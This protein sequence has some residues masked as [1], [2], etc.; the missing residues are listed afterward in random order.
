MA[1]FYL[2]AAVRTV[3]EANYPLIVTLVILSLIS[4]RLEWTNL[5]PL[6]LAMAGAWQIVMGWRLRRSGDVVAG[7][8][9]S[10]VSAAVAGQHTWLYGSHGILPVHALLVILLAAGYWY[11][12][13]T[14][15]WARRA[16]VVLAVI[17]ASI[18]ALGDPSFLSE[19]PVWARMIYPLAMAALLAGYSHATGDV[20]TY[21]GGAAAAAVGCADYSG[22]A[23]GYLHHRVAGLNELAWALFF[24]LLAA[25]I[26]LLKSGLRPAW[27]RRKLP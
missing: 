20:W 13:Q 26:S 6:P 10:L 16:A 19:V 9:L 24:F 12:D 14:G 5:D 21:A 1:A 8:C 17:L 25:L 15:R 4:A 11:R 27:L 23:Y 7:L 2:L 18:A 22:R 3:A